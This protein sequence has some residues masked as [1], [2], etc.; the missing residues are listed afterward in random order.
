MII[1]LAKKYFHGEI[2]E[3]VIYKLNFR[4]VGFMVSDT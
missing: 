3:L 1:I 4:C 2:I